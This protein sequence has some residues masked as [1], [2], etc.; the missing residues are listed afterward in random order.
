[1]A[2]S[3][4]G[5]AVQAASGARFASPDFQLVWRVRFSP[6]PIV[7]L[8]ALQLRYLIYIKQYLPLA[9]MTMPD[10]KTAKIFKHGRSQAVRLPKEFRMPGTKVSVRRVGRGV[11]LEPIDVPF[12]VK[13]WFGKL[14]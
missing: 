13:A 10:A 7:Q 8:L 2:P 3:R 5:K 14:D 12:D 9:W 6:L 11:M 4:R 1:A